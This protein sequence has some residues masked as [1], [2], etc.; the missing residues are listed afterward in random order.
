M[1]IEVKQAD[2]SDRVKFDNLMQFYVYDFSE[3]L[4]ME[5]DENGSFTEEILDDYF[6]DPT[7][8]SF[9]VFVDGKLAGF[10]LVNSETVL[11]QNQGGRSIQEFFIMRMYRRQGVGKIVAT[12]IFSLYTGRWE[13]RV[14]RKNLPARAY[15]KK[16]IR[17][18]S[19]ERYDYEERD[20][21]LWRGSIFSL[22]A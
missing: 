22:H 15:W 20:D 6:T 16:V 21:E 2:S 12:Q 1:Q 17:E 9:L 7:K 8:A 13:V 19:E 18:Y 5:L 11:Q 4:P 3:F 14:V 10:V